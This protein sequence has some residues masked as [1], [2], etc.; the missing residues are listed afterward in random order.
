LFNERP[1][2]TFTR[3]GTVLNVKSMATSLLY[4]FDWIAFAQRSST[5]TLTLCEP[6]TY[7]TAAFASCFRSWLL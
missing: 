4:G 2:V 1:F 3:I 6:V 7:E 5:P